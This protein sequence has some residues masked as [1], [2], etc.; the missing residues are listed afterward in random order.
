L[1]SSAAPSSN[2]AVRGAL[3]EQKRRPRFE[4]RI[5]RHQLAVALLERGEV[6]AFLLRQLLK[7]GPAARVLREV[8][9]ARIELE[10]ASFRRDGN[11]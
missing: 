5:G 2:N 4:R 9:G 7:D 3:E 6:L 8:R 1:R 10:T 11:P